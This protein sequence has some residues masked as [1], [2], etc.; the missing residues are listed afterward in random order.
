M[1]R[2]AVLS[3]VHSN[4]VAFEAVCADL[5]TV[6][7]DAI[8]YLG[9]LVMKGPHPVE[10]VELLRSLEPEKIVR[11]NY[12]NMF[13]RFPPDGWQP[14][15]RKETVIAEDFAYHQS[16]LDDSDQQWL[17]NLPTSATLSVEGLSLELYHATPDSLHT[18]T[19]PWAPNDEILSLFASDQTDIVL[20]GHIHHSFV[21]YAGGKVVVNPGSIGLPFDGDPRASY[22]VVDMGHGQLATQIRRVPFDIEL[23]I[24]EASRVGMPG[25]AP[26]EGA[27]RSARYPKY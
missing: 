15:N 13:T 11:G 6:S 14:R 4:L 21:R 10:C 3:D 20:F 5:Q 25:L 7:P 23:A 1:L 24:S 8:V 17:G 16:L 26:Y 19:W 18:I 22:A 12:D 2:L 9:D 27:L